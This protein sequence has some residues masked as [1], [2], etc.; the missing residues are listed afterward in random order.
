MKFSRFYFLIQSILLM[1][2]LGSVYAWGVFRVEA[3]STYQISASL[4]GL[5]YMT[6]LVSYAVTMLIAGKWMNQYRKQIVMLGVVLFVSGFWLSSL[7]SNFY[8][9]ILT[10]G[11][12]LGSG[13]GLL[14]GV[15]IYLVQRIFDKRIGLYSG[16]VLMGFGLS[17]TVMT[18]IIATLL[19]THTIQYTMMILGWISLGVFLVCIWPLFQTI[20][21][22]INHHHQVEK[23]I[24]TYDHKS[25][26]SLY[27][28]YVLSLLSGLTI[29]GLSFPIGVTNYQFDPTFVTVAISIFSLLN[30]ISRPFF[31]G[32]VDRFGFFKVAFLSL[33]S[34]IMSGFVSLFNGGTNETLYAISFGAF[35]FGLGNWMALM[36][37]SIKTIFPKE[38]FSSL[39]GK[40]FTAYGVAAILGTLFSGAILDLTNTTWPIYGVI[41]IANT[42]NLF[43]V[44]WLKRRFHIKIFN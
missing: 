18:P 43:L 21:M 34:L 22:E 37:L 33:I 15:P 38:L 28:V 40:L 16:L 19:A 44:L 26:Q 31:G 23:T 14:Y 41:V 10:Y 20:P 8:V 32:L 29:V 4:S 12:F 17:N 5:P 39:Y 9:L 1:L 2:L 30:G 42:V 25:F 6:S 36:P 11:V 24:T 27:V 7:A 3:E 35:W 13:V